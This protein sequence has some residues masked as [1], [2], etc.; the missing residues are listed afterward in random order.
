[1]TP[2][3]HTAVSYLAGKATRLPVLGVIAGGLWPD[4]DFLLLPLRHDE[5]TIEEAGLEAEV[6]LAQE[7]LAATLTAV[8]RKLRWLEVS[9]AEIKR[10]LLERL[11][12][13]AEGQE[14]LPFGEA[15]SA[16]ATDDQFSLFE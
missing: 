14:A 15:T 6:A 10:F 8:A 13:R 2:I 11:R 4:L 1:M 7:R 16:A 5:Q 3:G 9:E 12:Q